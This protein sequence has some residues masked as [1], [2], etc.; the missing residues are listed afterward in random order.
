MAPAK[1]IITRETFQFFKDL[2]RHNH[3]D[4]MYANRERYEAT[5]VQ[6]FRR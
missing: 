1:P 4:W 3:K 2:G 6:P 5:V